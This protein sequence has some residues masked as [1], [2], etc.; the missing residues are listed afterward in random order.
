[1]RCTDIRSGF[2]QECQSHSEM[3]PVQHETKAVSMCGQE[4]GTNIRM[5]ADRDCLRDY[6]GTGEPRQRDLGHMPR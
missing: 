1:M 4:H 6:L 2:L 5:T 3:M